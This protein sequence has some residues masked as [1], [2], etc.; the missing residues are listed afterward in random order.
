MDTLEETP[1]GTADEPTPRPPRRALDR[2]TVAICVCVALVAA[3]VAG[4][5]ASLLIDDD[6]GGSA[7][8]DGSIQLTDQIDAEE[9]FATGLVTIEGEATTLEAFRTD[10][11][12]VVNIW[13]QNCVPC[14]DEMPLLEQAHLANPDLTFVGV[15]TQDQLE[16]ALVMAE[17]TGITY[18][19]VQDPTGDF[20]FAAKG[21]GMPTTFI[22][23]PSGEVV[24]SKTG[25]FDSQADLQGW[26]DR[27]VA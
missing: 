1:T 25:A 22:V 23:M 15:D 16:K 24:A 9:L 7:G 27:H 10:E 8:S 18:P 17:Q 20:F 5:A 19:W 14:I 2:R 11:P 13:A 6:A 26:L 4:L 21:A 3:L 12:I